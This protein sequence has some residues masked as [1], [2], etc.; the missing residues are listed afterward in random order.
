MTEKL[1]LEKLNKIEKYNTKMELKVDRIESTVSLIAVQ[2]ERLDN[3]ANQ[4]N[5]LSERYDEVF[6]PGGY[7]DEI[8]VHQAACP[9]DTMKT[10]FGE[11]WA[12]YALLA[13]IVVGAFWTSKGGT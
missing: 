7:I 10:R 4:T 9:K 12:A 11:L 6:K 2:S 1:I 3:L 8:K 13:A 5:R